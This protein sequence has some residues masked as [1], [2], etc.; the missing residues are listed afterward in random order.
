LDLFCA[1]I[2]TPTPGTRTETN[3]IEEKQFP[4]STHFTSTGLFVG[5]LLLNKKNMIPLKVPK[6]PSALKLLLFTV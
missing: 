2:D 4:G 6:L 5:S 1:L 3:T